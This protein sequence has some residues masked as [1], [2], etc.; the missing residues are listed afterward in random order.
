MTQSDRR[1]VWAGVLARALSPCVTCSV[2]EGMERVNPTFGS[3]RTHESSYASDLTHGSDRTHESEES[4]QSCESQSYP[5]YHSY[6]S[7]SDQSQSDRTSRSTPPVRRV[8]PCPG[9][10]NDFVL[11]ATDRAAMAIARCKHCRGQ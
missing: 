1:S 9:C 6:E 2:N 10:G 8:K 3:D 4:D 11:L 7:Q 5:A